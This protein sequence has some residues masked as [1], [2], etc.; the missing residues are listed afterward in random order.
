MNTTSAVM[1]SGGMVVA[2]R[3]AEGKPMEARVVVGVVALVVILSAMPDEIAKPFALLIL[4][5]AAF[6][7]GLPLT[8]R[9]GQ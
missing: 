5:G 7:Y 2:G 8:Q 1:L 4:I 9:I 3:W 6:R